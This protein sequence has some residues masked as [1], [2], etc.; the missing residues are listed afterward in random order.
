MGESV[1]KFIVL[2]AAVLSVSSARAELTNEIKAKLEPRTEAGSWHGDWKFEIGGQTMDEG[3][4]ESTVAFIGA[5]ARV[6]YNATSWLRVKALPLVEA[7][8]GR[9]QERFDDTEAGGSRFGVREAYVGLRPVEFFELRA[10]AIYQNF[11]EA[12]QVVSDRRTF[13]GA[14]EI[15]S[16]K[17]NN[18][19]GGSIVLQQLIPT[20][21]S[22]NSERAEKEK[23]PSFHTQS[24][25]VDGQ[26][27]DWFSWSGRAGHFAWSELPRKVAAQSQIDGNTV[28]GELTPDSR[29][30]Y[31][32]DGYFWGAK[33]TFLEPGSLQP[34]LEYSGATNTMAPT[35]NRD[36]EIIGLGA[37]WAFDSVELKAMFKHYFSEPDI[38]P[39]YYAS[40]NFG[41]N[42]RIGDGVTVEAELRKLKL[43]V[44][45]EWNQARTINSSSTQDTWNFFRLSLESAY[46]SF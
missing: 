24:L 6:N 43:T 18:F 42:N 4:D 23:M 17:F 27:W 10:G 45:G 16:H 35:A 26:P 8:G 22:F 19:I 37:K 3:N 36:A 20:S 34:I 21:V 5:R 15:A 28:A 30:L 2:V 14:Q 29:F 33:L 46:A 12:P 44:R 32:F 25:H 7:A 40:S 38:S 41:R 1:Q 9:I 13:I 39:A 31:G 11:L